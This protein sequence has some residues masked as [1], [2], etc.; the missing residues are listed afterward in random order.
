MTYR[1]CVTTAELT[2]RFVPFMKAMLMFPVL[3]VALYW[4][5]SALG[6]DLFEGPSLLHDWLYWR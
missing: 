4:I 1:R 6:V 3:I 5:K 2:A